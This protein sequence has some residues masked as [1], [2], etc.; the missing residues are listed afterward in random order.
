MSLVARQLP[1]LYNGVSQQPATTRLPSQA[2]AQVNGW[3]SVVD[4]LKKRPP[5]EHL[6]LLTASDFT[7]AYTHVINRDANEKYIVVLLDGVLKVF[8]LDGNEKTVTIP[9]RGTAARSFAYSTVGVTRA[10]LV[11]NGYLY[12]VHTA[13]TT[14]ASEPTW[15]TTLGD[16]VVDGTVT[17]QCVPDYLRVD[18]PLT[19]FACVT[20][21]DFTFLVNKTVYAAMAPIGADE[22][23]PDVSM[24]SITETKKKKKG[25]ARLL[26]E[27]LEKAV[28][29][30]YP[31]NG[32][33]GAFKGTKQ[34]L[35]DIPTSPAPVDGDIWEIQGTS[36]TGFA[37]YYVRRNGGVWD[38]TVEPNLSNRILECTMPHALVRLEDGTFELQPF[39]WAPRRVG[40]E[41][42]NPNPSFIG[43]QI[44][45]VF[46]YKNRLGFL[47]DEN[48]VLSRAGDFG[49]FYRLTVVDLLDDE[50]VDIAAS[51]TQVTKLNF[52]VPFNSALMVF[53]DQ[54]QFIAAASGAVTPG[55]MSLDVATRYR[56]VPN[57]RPEGMGSDLYMVSEGDTYAR[58]LEYYVREGENSTE[59]ADITAH[60]PRYIPKG[61]R[62]LFGSAD[63]DLLCVVTSGAPNRL[64]TYKF[65]WTGENDKAQSA[66]SYW[67]FLPG[68]VILDGAVLDSNLYL[69]IQR[70]DGVYLERCD[71]ESGALAGTDPYQVYLDR[72]SAVTG[73]YL[74][75]EG[76]TEWSLPYPVEVTDRDSFRLVQGSALGIPG[77]TVSV[78]PADYE[79]TSSVT[80][81]VAGNYAGTSWGGML[82]E[83]RYTFSEQFMKNNADV[84]V[85]TGRLQLRTWTVYFTD[86]AY[87]NTE[88]APY[89]DDPEIEEVVPSKFAT[90]DGKTVGLS[91]LVVGE[92]VY[93]EGAYSF[94]VYGNS[95]VA[96]I[97]LVNDSPYASNFQAAEWEGFY[98]NRISRLV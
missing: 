51:T 24:F 62:A 14:G 15:P 8:D 72:R 2:Q 92:P 66:W 56:M 28:R 27:A 61:V 57:V 90:F 11:P 86:T 89:G 46:F 93:A 53:A 96:V 45:E 23:V 64:Y 40:N 70:S 32:P 97:S 33:A 10:P 74:S 3:S 75:G 81:K 37:T 91:A 50:T 9:G 58:V 76:K 80:V 26:Q 77:G 38:E 36:E 59:A 43:R 42:T 12:R 20:V 63:L 30:Q 18:N 52:A 6:A 78:D 84:P 34:S 48:V 7:G 13:G 87:F 31:A 22:H 83:F 95:D 39:S 98:Q 47:V 79:W 44:R 19:D 82:Y 5:T 73:V 71:L 54:V 69:V 29:A 85:T 25:K 41:D 55:T 49:N 65:Y 68:D 94:Q 35:Q 60:V 17:W 16:T 67:E 1:A 88:V 21:A 4:G